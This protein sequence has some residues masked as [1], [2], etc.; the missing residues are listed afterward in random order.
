MEAWARTGHDPESI[1][2][3]ADL[4]WHKVKYPK[5][6]KKS[7]DYI[8]FLYCPESL[9][10]NK[11]EDYLER[12]PESDPLNDEEYFCEMKES[13]DHVKQKE[14]IDVIR[15]C[16]EPLPLKQRIKEKLITIRN[17]I[18]LILGWV[19]MLFVLGMMIVSFLSFFGVEIL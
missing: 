6:D 19:L 18:C 14:L 11:V 17:I 12:Y 10:K 5:P 4:I 8:A 1:E 9:L 15:E 2:K 3:Y 16:L 13:P 7:D